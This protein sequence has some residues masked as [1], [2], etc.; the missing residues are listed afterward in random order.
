MMTDS[1]AQDP[2]CCGVAI[3]ARRAVFV[4][5]RREGDLVRDVTGQETQITIK[6][7]DNPTE[8]RAFCRT[9]HAVFDRMQPDRIGIVQR[10]KK[11]HFA[12]GG[13]TFKLEGLLQLYPQTDVTLVDPPLLRQF[14][15]EQRPILAPRF[16]YQK[17]A[18]LL[19]L[20]LLETLGPK[21]G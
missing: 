2:V 12:S 6:D 7:E 4:F 19:A 18:Y 15:K 13:T 9:A 10:K 17:E 20:Y 11:G 16:Q 1:A 21:V 5:L 14:V 3:A 8:I